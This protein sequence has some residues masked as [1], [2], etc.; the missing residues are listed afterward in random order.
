MFPRR[1]VVEGCVALL[2]VVVAVGGVVAVV[3]G[4]D[5]VNQQ[6]AYI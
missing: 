3:S 6:N 4:V 1:V 5:P 2:S